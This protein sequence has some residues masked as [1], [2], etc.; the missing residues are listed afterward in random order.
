MGAILY[1]DLVKAVSEA[2]R[3]GKR[4]GEY[5]VSEGLIQHIQMENAL[6]RQQ[7]G[8]HRSAQLIALAHSATRD[9]LDPDLAEYV[10]DVKN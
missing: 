2:A 8:E 10:S 3:S 6:A 7:S 5:L 4:L 9:H 1:P